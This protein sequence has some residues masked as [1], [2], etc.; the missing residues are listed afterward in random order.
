V[1]AVPATE[2]PVARRAAAEVIDLA[3]EATVALSFSRIGYEARRWARRW[4]DLVPPLDHRSG[5]LAGR[6]AV[7]TGASSGLGL[8][9]ATRVAGLGAAV[10]LLGRDIART[11]RARAHIVERTGNDDIEIGIADLARLDDVRRYAAQIRAYTPRLDLL[12]NN[13]GALAHHYER[14][15]DGLELATQTHVVAPFLLTSELLPLLAATPGSRVIAVTS[16]GMYTQR[17]VVDR[18]DPDPIGYD[19][20]ATYARAKRAQV[21]LTRLWAERARG[22]D[23]HFHAMHPGWVDT[24]GLRAAV[25]GF[26]KMAG[27]WLRDPDQGADTLVW[28]AVDDV[29]TV[30]N[31]ELWLDRHRRWPH[32]LPWTPAGPEEPARLWAWVQE[33][34]GLAPADGERSASLA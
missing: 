17:L 30:T 21:V 7:I 25:P 10:R 27:R 5:P 15:V 4:D 1:D 26:A 11:E 34:A 31:G 29:A 16:G 13:A 22:T 12:V 14:T 23:V 33:R 19:G 9:T 32:K 8:A 3:L 28:L 6:V 18:L 2:T 20:V 24:P